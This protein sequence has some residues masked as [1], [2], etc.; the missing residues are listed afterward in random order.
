MKNILLP[1]GFAE[2]KGGRGVGVG[3]SGFQVTGMI[4]GCFF[5]W[6]GGEIFDSEVFFG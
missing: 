2:N 5:F 4:K 6:G 3:F 1:A